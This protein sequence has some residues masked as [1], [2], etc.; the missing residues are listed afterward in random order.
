MRFVVDV[1]KLISRYKWVLL[2]VF[3]LWATFVFVQMHWADGL[4]DAVKAMHGGG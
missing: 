4:L 1:M 2:V 3:L